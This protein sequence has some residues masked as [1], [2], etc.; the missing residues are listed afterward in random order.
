MHY[1]KFLLLTLISFFDRNVNLL[2]RKKK[3]MKI[4]FN[5]NRFQYNDIL[6]T[7]DKIMVRSLGKGWYIIYKTKS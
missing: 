5:D 3:C 7:H 4:I 2:F 1:L 6:T